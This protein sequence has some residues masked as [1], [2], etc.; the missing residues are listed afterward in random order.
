MRGLPW[1]EVRSG[2]RLAVGPVLLE[3]SL[4]SLP[5][6]KNAQWFLDGDFQRI[7][8]ERGP[9]SRIYATVLEPGAI[10]TGDVVV[11]EP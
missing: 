4:F 2:V 6:T 11:L 3:A 5:C 8:H 1:T 9:V 10:A 7:H